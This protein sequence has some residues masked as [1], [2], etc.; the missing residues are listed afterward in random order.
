[1]NSDGENHLNETISSLQYV[2]TY[3]VI[4]LFLSAVLIAYLA[5]VL[6][7]K[8]LVSPLQLLAQHLEEFPHK[9]EGKKF[10]RISAGGLIGA[11]VTAF[12]RM[13]EEIDRQKAVLQKKCLPRASK[14]F[15]EVGLLL[16]H[17]IKMTNFNPFFLL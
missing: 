8:Y 6:L 11:L 7:V 17:L 5:K 12:N 14:M 3:I 16:F 15:V 13:A 2:M 1:M 9:D 10:L 4:V